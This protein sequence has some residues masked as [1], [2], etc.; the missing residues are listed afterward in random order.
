MVE[1]VTK[2]NRRNFDEQLRGMFEDRK[3]VFVDLLKWDLSVIDGCL[4]IDQFDDDHAIY[5]L[6][7]HDDGSH[8]GSMR[9]LPTDRPHILG[10]FFSHLSEKPVP[11]GLDTYE[12]TR[13]CLSPR[14]RAVERRYVRNQLISAMTDFALANGINT[15][16]GVARTSWL[17]QILRMGWR[18][19]TLGS[20]QSVD[21]T[22]TGAFRIDLDRDTP[23]G[24]AGMGIYMPGTS[25]AFEERLKAFQSAARDRPL[26]TAS[27]HVADDVAV[28]SERLRTDGYC[29][30]PNAIACETVD[31]LNGDLDE[32]FAATPFSEG[33]FYGPRTKRF[34]S[35]LTRSALAADL[36]QHHLILGIAQTVLGPWCDRFNLNLTHSRQ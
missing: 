14:L 23:A 30:I 10:S 7:S 26:P 36:V 35:L 34:G 3:I 12:V 15:L 19:E 2:K 4:E 22:L 20:V 33:G 32:R 18:C 27:A 5:L 8:L 25:A 6:A 24:L 29:I 31:K 11:T 17:A 16:T 1:I 13:L 9:L 21:G 28:W